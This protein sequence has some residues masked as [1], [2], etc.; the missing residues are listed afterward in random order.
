M[1]IYSFTQDQVQPWQFYT[2]VDS[3]VK[4][5]YCSTPLRHVCWPAATAKT[6]FE[7]SSPVVK[8]FLE[9]EFERFWTYC[10]SKV[11]MPARS[12]GWM[13]GECVYTIERR[14]MVLKD[15]LP[16]ES[17]DVQPLRKNNVF[18]GIRAKG[19]AIHEQ[20]GPLGRP[21]GSRSPRGRWYCHQAKR[22]SLF[23]DSDLYA[24]WRPWRRLT[25]RDGVEEISDLCAYRSG[26][27]FIVTRFPGEDHKAKFG[28]PTTSPT[29]MISAREV[30]RELG[31][32]V[33]SGAAI[34][35]P[36]NRYGPDMGGGFKYE[37]DFKSP[38][39]NLQQIEDKIKNLKALISFSI[40]SPTGAKLPKRPKRG[41]ASAAG[42]FRLQTFILA[43]QDPVTAIAIAWFNQI[44]LPLA[45]WNFGARVWARMKVLPLLRRLSGA[46]WLRAARTTSGADR[47]ACSSLAAMGWND[48][49]PVYAT[50]EASSPEEEQPEQ[51]KPQFTLATL[52]PMPL[53]RM[54]TAHAP[55]GGV[56]IAGTHFV[57]GQFIP[58]DVLAKA[59][60]EEKAKIEDKPA[61]AAKAPAVD[62][63]TPH[64][65]GSKEDP[66]YMLVLPG[67][68]DNG[69]D[70]FVDKPMP[71]YIPAVGKMAGELV[72]NFAK[73]LTDQVAKLQE[74][75][76]EGDDAEAVRGATLEASKKFADDM[77]GLLDRWGGRVV[78]SLKRRF[79]ADVGPGRRRAKKASS[80][81][82][83]PKSRPRVRPCS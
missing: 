76:F 42:L 40:G 78:D 12:Y 29:G 17:K 51:G 83:S 82:K 1:P 18:V 27:G 54:A 74:D 67:Q 71:Q 72:M 37:I 2:D 14:V 22:G 6:E 3:M 66:Y 8:K 49:A 4:S 31:E 58:G 26:A 9:S 73:K 47:L 56:T 60:P 36:S 10:L 61:E 77:D 23:G 62:P 24:A 19:G 33:K 75:F 44:G 25:G 59:T 69:G 65:R 15:L 81:R 79:G 41:A 5:A 39:T 7:A 16:F 38:P 55:T 11:Q 57:G 48:G 43:Q 68:G 63:N 13:G 45:R 30:M 50:R 20:L 52:P 28:A 53:M 80:P 70:K 35:L 46:C 64:F 34:N 21:R 32:N